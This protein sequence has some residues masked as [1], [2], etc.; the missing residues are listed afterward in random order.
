[1]TK[2]SL[3]PAALIGVLF[4]AFAAAAAG[5]GDRLAFLFDC[6]VKYIFIALFPITLG[7][8]A[9]APEILRSWLGSDFA[10]Q[11]TV[12]V[13]LLAV[14]VFLNGLANV[15]FAHLQSVGRADLTAKLH[16]CELPIYLAALFV[17]VKFLG[18]RGAAIAWLARVA[19]DTAI[20]FF[21]SRRA[22]RE[23]DLERAKLL[24]M[25]SVAIVAFVVA[26]LPMGFGFKLV[27][28][29][30]LLVAGGIGAWRWLLSPKEKNFFV[31]HIIRTRS[32]RQAG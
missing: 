3:I 19:M 2:L 4:P 22:L 14:A 6:G 17:L 1:V 25:V 29:A 12:V 7:L 13:R 11:S 23:Y 10:Q 21:L 8:T 30:C 18:I 24:L 5:D 32:L 31:G 15:P 28:V 26:T 27:G 16:L 9:F 20:L